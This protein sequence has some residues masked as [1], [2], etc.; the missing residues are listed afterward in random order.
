M[1]TLLIIAAI[2]C[3]YKILA[4]L[5]ARQKEAARKSEAERIRKE[6]ESIRAE[7][8]RQREQIKAQIERAK[9]ETHERIEAEKRRIEWQKHQDK[10]NRENAAELKRQAA[11]IEK[12]KE[13]Q[14][15]MRFQLD[16]ALEDIPLFERQ[17]SVLSSQI[18]AWQDA[19]AK[20]LRDVEWDEHRI[21][22]AGTSGVVKGKEVEAHLK[23]KEQAENKII[24]L[25]TKIR[26]T[27][28]KLAKARFDRDRAK[29]KLA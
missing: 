11:E 18:E 23:A 21:K 20:A 19:Y 27:E 1:K 17:L 15:K 12:V 28:K 16:Q 13:E 3:A 14:I 7:Q 9:I 22:F 24:Q 10:I 2:F 6:Q 26:A 8:A 29:E 5:S 25:E 4:G